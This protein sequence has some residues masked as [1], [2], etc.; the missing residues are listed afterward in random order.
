MKLQGHNYKF[1]FEMEKFS[2]QFWKVAAQ[3]YHKSLRT[4]KRVFRIGRQ[5]KRV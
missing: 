5:I 3:V 4:K 2:L 1:F